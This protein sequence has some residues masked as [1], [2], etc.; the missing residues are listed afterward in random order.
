[1]DRDD[2]ILKEKIL[3]YI[4]DR[5]ADKLEKFD[6]EYEKKLGKGDGAAYEEKKLQLNLQRENIENTHKPC[7]WLTSAASRAKQ[8]SLA[9]FVAKY[10]H[11]DTKGISIQIS[12][13][14]QDTSSFKLLHTAAI[15]DLDVDVT[16]NA[17]ALDVAKLECCFIANDEP[18]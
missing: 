14:H 10:T 17:A 4:A 9:H 3:T 16:G 12:D 6:K 2:D 11:S 15:S 5:A 13:D 8:I 1:M 7:A 18:M